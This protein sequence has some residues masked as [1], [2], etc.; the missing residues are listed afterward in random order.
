[1]RPASVRPMPTRLSVNL[2]KVATVRNARTEQPADRSAGSP[3]LL[4]AA[5]VCIEAGAGGITVHPRPD[6]RHITF[7]DVRE[8]APIVGEA[9]GVEYNIEGDPRNDLVALV[10]E[11]RP[12]QFTIVPVRPGE[13]TSE[14][15][16]P[17]STP[18]GPLTRLIE[19]MRSIDVRVSMFVNPDPEQVRWAAGL[20]AARIELFTEPFAAAFARS[21]AAGQ[22]SF[23]RYVE[24]AEVAAKEGLTINAGHDLDETN[25]VLFRDLPQLAEV[26]IGHALIGR[27]LFDGLAPVVRRYLAVLAD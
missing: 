20:G 10:R 19:D 11:V 14:A 13:I 5:K 18:T 9:S 8:L 6:R 2:N 17:A 3:S 22:E 1:M 25:L 24:A 21:L 15:G 4:E 12:D 7:A 23:A 27:A 16:W 26:S